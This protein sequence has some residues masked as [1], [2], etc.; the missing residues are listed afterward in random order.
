MPDISHCFPITDPTLIF[1]VVLSIIL[2]APIIMGKLRIPHIVGMVLAGVVVGKYGFNVLERDSSFELFGKVGLYYI[3]FLAGLEMDF[4]GLKN[5]GRTILS[6]GLLNFFA[7]FFIVYLAGIYI[8]G[9]SHTATLL[10]SSIMA[11]NTLIAY[12]IVCKY[13]LQR[14]RAVTLCVG[15]S[16]IS[17]TLALMVLAAIV[18]SFGSGTG[19]GFW[20][21]FF[22]KIALFLACSIY[23]LPKLTRWF[24]QRWSDAV[25]Q[26]IFVMT[27]MFMSAAASELI[28][29]EG[30]F[31]AFL[32][33][34]IL[35][36]Y[37]PHVSPLMNR[38]EFIGNALFIPYFLIGVGMLINVRVLWGG[39]HAAFIIF[40]IIFFGTLG[41]AVASYAVAFVKRMP[42]SNGN[43]MF[44]LTSAHAAGSIAIATVGMKLQVAPGQMLVDSDMLNG[45]VIMILVT[46]IIGSMM[47]DRAARTIVLSENTM[48]ADGSVSND[49]KILIPLKYKGSTDNL[50]NLAIM[51]RNPKLNRGIIGINLVIDDDKSAHN[52]ML[53]KRL[54]EQA[55][56][57][58][59]AADVRMQTQIR[60]TTNVANG[61]MHAFK[62]YDASE[63][64]MGMHRQKDGSD[65]FWG[66]FT[67]SLVAGLNRQ[68]MLLRHNR[69]LN[70]VRRIHVAVP[71]RVEFEP[72]FY[73]WVGRLAQLADNIGCK[74]VFY[75]REDSTSLISA[76]IA[77][78]H[79]GVR[80][81]YVAMPHWKELPSLAEK[82]KDDHLMV[83]VTA[84]KGT[85]S[86]KPVFERL[87]EEIK[88][89][90]G[91][92]ALMIVFP[93]QNG[94]PPETM[95]FTAPQTHNDES[96][97]MAITKW[98]STKMKRAGT[99]E[100]QVKDNN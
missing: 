52:Q 80:A 59:S 67:P 40:C 73:R 13:G 24:L 27:V 17:L 68:I 49:E 35:N 26:Y 74:I 58:A 4:N 62:E 20:A 2:F 30:V 11:S 72:G 32:A 39:W 34:L 96:A 51:T 33:G 60:L 95:T 91:D 38:I 97:Y 65:R 47:T 81:E 79:R 55:V 76:Y 99:V 84:R 88:R 69:P 71:S 57:G 46:C 29:L 90:F 64:I 25:T 16:M 43:M 66:E 70:T 1:F 61:I 15:A 48:P 92:R 14:H 41:K 98:I 36:R 31:G 10:L 28:G 21:M 75:G 89:F 6:F 87:P 85:V 5:N 44:G 18:G 54:L 94:Q 56:K 77:A 7:P 37:I 86:Y 19:V 3:M 45:V 9:Y 83:I 22:V 63:I 82:V 50:V 78:R 12:P 23:L 100:R 42:L 53:G 93:D 8:M